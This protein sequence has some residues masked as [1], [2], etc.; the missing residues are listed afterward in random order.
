ML[1][2]PLGTPVELKLECEGYRY[3]CTLLRTENDRIEFI[4]SP[5][6][7]KDEIK[8]MQ[9][10]RWHGR[11]D[12]PRK[13]WSVA[14]SPRNLFQLEWLAGGNPYAHWEKEVTPVPKSSRVRPLYD[15]QWEGTALL[16]ARRQMILA[17]EMGCI[18]GDAMLQVNRAGKGFKM[19]FREFHRKINGGETRK[20]KWDLNIPTY[21]R[22][23]KG[24]IL[25]QHLVIKSLYKGIKKVLK[26]TLE[27]GKSITLTPDHEIFTG[28][29]ESTRADLLEVGSTVLSNGKW[30]DK[31]CGKVCFVPVFDKVVSIEDAGEIDVY[32]LVMDD[33]HHNFVADGVVVHNCGKTL[34]AIE[35][36]E[37]SGLKDWL[38]VA[39]KSG[40]RAA[41][42]EFEKWNCKIKPTL[43]SYR[44]FTLRVKKWGDWVPDGVIFDESSRLKT[45]STQ[46][47]QAA[48][49]IADRIREVHGFD[50]YVIEMTGSPSPKA[51]IDWWSQAEI[52]CPG[53]LREGST[54]ALEY[55][56]G[57]H[58]EIEIPQ[59]PTRLRIGWKDDERK[60]NICG[61]YKPDVAEEL[62]QIKEEL[63]IKEV[64][65]CDEEE[66]D[67]E[68]SI[69]EVELI[70][71][72]LDGLAFFVSKDKHLDLPEKI[73]E[74]I[75]LEP[76]SSMLRVAKVIADTAPS[77]IQALTLLRE[78][79]DGFQ[80]REV[81]E[82]KTE[83]KYCNGKGEVDDYY[84][85]EDPYR[86]LTQADFAGHLEHRVITCP[87]CVGTGEVPKKVRMTRKVTCPKEEA[88]IEQ[89]DHNEEIGRLVV[90]AGFSGSIDRVTEICL[91]YGWDVVKVDGRGWDVIT[92]DGKKRVDPL[93]YWADMSNQKVVFVAHPQSGGMGL[94]LVEARTC[95]YYS[96]DF[97]P[98]SRTQSEER[99]H[100]PGQD[101]PVRIID[102]IHLPTDTKVLNT[103]KDNRRLE[104]MTLGE[105]R[106]AF[107]G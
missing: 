55:R 107:T 57:I 34:M 44:Q 52:A 58:R 78:L 37:R 65:V 69:N 40:L 32:D 38:W 67:Y 29:N 5:F 10:S 15:Y 61:G 50:G 60:C 8:A 39:P 25:G 100:R 68:P 83:C 85:P 90:F 56:L 105:L 62:E 104:K 87:V 77:A 82:G 81:D 21:V 27:S 12:K 70:N 106:E 6:K 98:E 86:S 9:G 16:L 96:N 3:P 89:L 75:N 59:G 30:T 76:S 22:A 99:I 7:M 97:N 51:P 54:K 103:L 14:Y 18:S 94:T 19:S 95:I 43:M 35:T 2:L 11:D 74:Q 49:W 42:R 26:V 36:M 23:L 80:Y 64:L 1:D 48:Q 45:A 91:K 93:D 63:N 46:R 31:D 101:H 79:S 17:A 20:R 84:D 47:A 71:D 53:F 72:R 92:K 66:H 4:R 73:Y 28:L 102:F 13:I 33:P 24:D 88:L 41:K